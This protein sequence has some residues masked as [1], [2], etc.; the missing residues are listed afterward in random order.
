[1]SVEVFH[2]T[3]PARPYRFELLP[4]DAMASALELLEQP[5]DAVPEEVDGAVE[6]GLGRALAFADSQAA[7]QRAALI[8][9][10]ELTPLAFP[11]MERRLRAHRPR[12]RSTELS[13]LIFDNCAEEAHHDPVRARELGRLA[14]VAAEQIASDGVPRAIWHDIQSETWAVVADVLRLTYDPEG[15]EAAF[16][17]A[18][19]HLEAGSGTLM[20]RAELLIRKASL[21]C[22][23]ERF[24]HGLRAIDQALCILRA[25]AR[26]PEIA[27]ALVAKGRLA[28]EGGR[29][30]VA[31]PLFE[32]ALELAGESTDRALV[33]AVQHNLAACLC[34]LGLFRQASAPLAVAAS[35]VKLLSRPLGR[36]QLR[37]LEGRH[38]VGLGD[39]AAAADAYAQAVDGFRSRRLDVPAR[40]AA[41]DLARLCARQGRRGRVE[42]W[43]GP[44]IPALRE[45]KGAWRA[46][47]VTDRSW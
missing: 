25:G 28:L 24:E 22:D 31:R 15:A 14:L 11:E 16:A 32:E 23:L 37:W 6:R 4:E 38:A 12:F 26:R 41:R 42:R 39:F 2:A 29:A 33:L 20:I 8:L 44:L 36:L 43:V 7:E 9:M 1:M 18:E 27:R 47:P 3:P 30:E 5:L 35:T 17:K 46:R 21:A 19:R 10:S 45:R 34:E 40:R 13:R